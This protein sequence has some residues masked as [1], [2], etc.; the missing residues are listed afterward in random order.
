MGIYCRCKRN[1]CHRQLSSYLRTAATARQCAEQPMRGQPC[2]GPAD[3]IAA[4]VSRVQKRRAAVRVL[5]A[6]DTSVCLSGDMSVR[7]APPHV[8]PSSPQDRAPASGLQPPPPG[9]STTTHAKTYKCAPQHTRTQYTQYTPAY[10]HTANSCS[11][12]HVHTSSPTSAPYNL[13]ST[14]TATGRGVL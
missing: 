13:L 10:T 4:A 8:V 7:T 3:A 1:Y 14:F 5:R 9:T 11:R 6:G 2:S 12:T